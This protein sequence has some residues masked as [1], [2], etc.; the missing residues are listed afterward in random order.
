[1]D[2]LIEV[3]S[4]TMDIYISEEDDNEE[5]NDG[6]DS[7]VQKEQQEKQKPRQQEPQQQPQNP[8]QPIISVKELEDKVKAAMV[9]LQE[10]IANKKK[11]KIP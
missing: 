2:T 4:D 11:K 10:I 3:H 6:N 5:S 7:N 9:K 1:M 8:H